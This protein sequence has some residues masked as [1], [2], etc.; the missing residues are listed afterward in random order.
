MVFTPVQNGEKFLRECMESVLGQTYRNWRYI[1][2]DNASA[3]TTGKMA[4]EY[5]R[6]DSRISV[7]RN[8]VLLPIMQNHNRAIAL[9]A[10]T[11]C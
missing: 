10:G 2:L 6:K 9:S 3:D 5:A 8:D 11:D 7:E 4:A 1:I